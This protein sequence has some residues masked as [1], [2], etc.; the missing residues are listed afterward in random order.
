M[1]TLTREYLIDKLQKAE[2]ARCRELL[3]RMD[4]GA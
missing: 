4:K 1:T 2:A 3:E